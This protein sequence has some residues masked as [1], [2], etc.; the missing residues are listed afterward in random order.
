M[1]R[2]AVQRNYK[3]EQGGRD[4]DFFTL[5]CWRGTAD[6]VKRFIAKGDRCAVVGSLQNR[7]WTDESG[8]KRMTTEVIVDEVEF[9]SGRKREDEEPPEPKRQEFVQVDDDELPF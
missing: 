4:A 8:A 9:V 7:D 2:L 5:V 1:F 3:N 6:L